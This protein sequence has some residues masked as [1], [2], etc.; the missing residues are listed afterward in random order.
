MKKAVLAIL[1]LAQLIAF[2]SC[3]NKKEAVNSPSKGT[4][5]ET[6][7]SIDNINSTLKSMETTVDSLKDA[8]DINTN[9]L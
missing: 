6:K 5:V 9:N 1:V 2:S 7:K 3:G 8:V 4:T